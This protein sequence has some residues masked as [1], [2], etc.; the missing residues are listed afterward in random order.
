MYINVIRIYVSQNDGISST[1]EIIY[2]LTMT[3]SYLHLYESFVFV[4]SELN[5]VNLGDRRNFTNNSI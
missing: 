1:L 2:T 4:V 3:I 5:H